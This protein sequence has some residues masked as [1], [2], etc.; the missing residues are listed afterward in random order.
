M[1]R[2][3][4]TR[5]APRRSHVAV[6]RRK[7]RPFPIE[8][9]LETLERF[10]RTL[11]VPVVTLAAEVSRDPFEVL[12]ACLLSLRTKDGTTAVAVKKLFARAKTPKALLGIPERELADLIYPVGFYRTKA[13]VLRE[14]ARTIL[15]DL[16]GS[17]PDTLEGLLEL[18]GVGRKTANLVITQAFQRPGICVD[19]HVHRIM[20]RFGFVRTKTP[21]ETELAL[22]A[23]L[24]VRFWIPVNPTLVA[25]GQGVCGPIS[26]RCSACPVDELCPK[27]GVTHRR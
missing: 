25:F 7:T 22:R 2:S 15:N 24:P 9:A 5:S 17:V 26:P 20:N 6:P 1:G 3:R 13:R 12:V 16:G 21:D 23:R 11:Q 18:R 14:V 10:A 27:V 4:L 8:R 19:T